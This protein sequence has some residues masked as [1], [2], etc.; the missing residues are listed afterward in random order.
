[1]AT[2]PKLDT[3]IDEL[4]ATPSVSATDPR[5]DQS[6]VPLINKLASWA[7]D[8]GFSAQVLPVRDTSAQAKK[9]NLVAV[10]GSGEGGLV[11]SGHTDTVPWDEARWQSNPFTATRRDGR[12]YGLGTADMKSFLALALT[13]A[14][15]IDDS[16]LCA[17]LVIVGTADEECTMGGA[18][19]L[20]AAGCVP[21]DRVI[22]GE[23]TSLR[24]V[25]M[26]KGFASE[27]IRLIG[28]SGHSSDP[29]LGHSVADGLSQLIDEL[30]RTRDVLAQEY[31]NDA[32]GVSHPTLNIGRV[33]GG[34]APNRILGECELL[35]DLRVLP[36][37]DADSL[38]SRIRDRLS[39]RL[40]ALGYSLDFESLTQTVPA[41][42]GHEQSELM[43]TLCAHAKTQPHAVAFATEAPFFS[44]MGKETVVWGPGSIDVAHQPN[45]FI[46]E[47]EVHATVDHLEA[48]MR[49]YCTKAKRE[50]ATS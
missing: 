20:E 44:A 18:R 10:R 29:K 27:R 34:D 23:P 33:A 39:E 38:R 15:R 7:E 48:L 13:A 50:S 11:L 28:Q 4:I 16:A 25:F 43:H 46:A 40:S 21:A 26:H 49:R 35:Y 30:L 17:P 36:G 19:M 1:M 24:P 12:I 9:A 47:A 32:F 31:K 2:L 8:S 45:E 14:E 3:L 42:E 41:F 22:I 37:M 5:L 6:N